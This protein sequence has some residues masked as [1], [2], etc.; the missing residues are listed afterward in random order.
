MASGIFGA[1]WMMHLLAWFLGHATAMPPLLR[2][3]K[4]CK[5]YVSPEAP[6]TAEVGC[7]CQSLRPAQFCTLAQDLAFSVLVLQYAALLHDA[8]AA[9][10]N[11]D[12]IT[13]S[14]CASG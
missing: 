5:A 4:S 10:R 7:G 1:T 13:R 2:S 6:L 12:I 9:G 8:A 3:S 14:C 11:R